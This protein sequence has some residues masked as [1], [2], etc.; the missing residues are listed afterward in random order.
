MIVGSFNYTVPAIYIN[1]EN[2]VIIGDLCETNQASI[3]KQEKLAKYSLGEIDRIIE[4]FGEEVNEWNRPLTVSIYQCR[5]L[6][7]Y[8][9]SIISLMGFDFTLIRNSN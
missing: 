9:R 8:S 3:Q 7:I 4:N 6:H 2:V 1:D 5:E